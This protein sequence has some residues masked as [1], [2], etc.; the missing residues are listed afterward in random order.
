[1][2]EIEEIEWEIEGLSLLNFGPLS[3][4]PSLSERQK[5]I[6]ITHN[7]GLTPRLLLGLRAEL[8]I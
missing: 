5:Q 7:S 2:I 4:S 8:D 3:T 1:M 6:Q